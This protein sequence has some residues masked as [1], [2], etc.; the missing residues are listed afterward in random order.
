MFL[1]ILLH[2]VCW[3]WG[4]SCQHFWKKTV[5]P[6]TFT[7]SPS[8][9]FNVQSI[10]SVTVLPHFPA[11]SPPVPFSK[12]S[13]LPPSNLHGSH[14]KNM[15]QL[16]FIILFI[17]PFFNLPLRLSCTLAQGS[18]VSGS[19]RNSFKLLISAV[20]SNHSLSYSGIQI[21][22]IEQFLPLCL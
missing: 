22:C 7:N 8:L 10:S 11:V 20:S 18:E 17:P 3:G 19:S 13:C 12:T 2:Q 16:S 4:C 1:L 15:F 14:L 6:R 21:F 5:P 9:H